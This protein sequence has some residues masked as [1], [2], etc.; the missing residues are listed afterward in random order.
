[1]RFALSAAPTSRWKWLTTGCV[2]A[3]LAFSSLSACAP[4]GQPPA[5]VDQ[6]ADRAADPSGGQAIPVTDDHR[7]TS[8]SM[9]RVRLRMTLDEARQA[10]AAASFTRT[11][12]GEGMALVQASLGEGDALVLA[13]DETDAAAAID[14]S[15]PILFIQTFSS[16]FHTAEGIAPGSLVTDV[17][18]VYGLIREITL[19]EI[20]ARQY[21]RFERQPMGLTFRLDYTGVF[22]PGES[23]TTRCE[24][25]AKLMGIEIASGP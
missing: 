13:A 12:D 23:R 7:I 2:L 17:V 14:W 3:A 16:K 19:S 15:K 9:G 4:K 20:E 8:D 25:G 1:M 10:L 11:S 6:S 5:P 22:A 21:I 18:G 24:P